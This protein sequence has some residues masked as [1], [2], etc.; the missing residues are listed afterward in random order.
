MIRR[1]RYPGSNGMI[2]RRELKRLKATTLHTLFSEVC[3]ALGLRQDVDFKFNAQD[4]TISF[5]NGPDRENPWN[6][7]SIIF[8]IDLAEKPSDPEY[9]R[10]GSYTLTDCFVDEAQEVSSK[11]VNVLKA[12]FS[13]TER[14]DR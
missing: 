8:C 5:P 6:G 11:A 2:G 10:L 9:D 3:P 14:K 13:L 12:R 4:F 7:G 1:I